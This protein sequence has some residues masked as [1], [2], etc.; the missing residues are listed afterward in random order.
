MP[1]STQEKVEQSMMPNIADLSSGTGT[2]STNPILGQS[3]QYTNTNPTSSSQS[4]IN[5]FENATMYVVSRLINKIY[6]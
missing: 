2:L 6:G 1:Q 5:K 4:P 3:T